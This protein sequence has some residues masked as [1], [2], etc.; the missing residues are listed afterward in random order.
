MVGEVFAGLGAFKTMFDMAKALKDINDAAIR[1]GAVI[2]LQEQILSAQAAQSALIDRV[3]DL[4]EKVAGFE[5]W[6][7]EKK[8]YE[9][10]LLGGGS[11][12]YMLKKEERGVSP[13]HWICAHCF[14]SKRIEVIQNVPGKGFYCPGCKNRIEPTM[15]AIVPFTATAKWLD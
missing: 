15:E 14:G 12:A 8:R 7:T 5:T 1:N 11:Y 9:L 6:E 3:R 13:P 2:E 10:K 4:E